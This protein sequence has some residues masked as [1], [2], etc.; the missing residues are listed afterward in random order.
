M[1]SR[2][3]IVSLYVILFAG[4]GVGA[5]LL[6][7]EAQAEYRQLK[8]VETASR[9]RLAVESARLQTQQKILE[10]LRTDPAFVEKVL[11]ER[12]G[13]ARPGEVIFRFPE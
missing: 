10:R 9:Q 12:W 5:G 11:R 6:F 8:L 7:Y 1:N 13:Y 4:F 3:L 2:P